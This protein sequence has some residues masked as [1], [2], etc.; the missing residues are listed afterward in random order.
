MASSWVIFKRPVDETE[1]E[2]CSSVDADADSDV[3]EIKDTAETIAAARA[4]AIQ[5]CAT[6]ASQRAEQIPEPPVDPPPP[7]PPS[8]KRRGCPYKHKAG[9][10]YH[11]YC[12]H[13]CF[14]GGDDKHTNNCSGAGLPVE[15][16]RPP[17]PPPSCRRR[18]CPYEHKAGPRHHGYCCHGCRR[19]G[20]DEHTNNCSGAG[21]PVK[22]PPWRALGA[23]P[24]PKRQRT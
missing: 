4:R 23:A 13:G 22:L 3:V 5:R 7:P 21:L 20:D 18:G 11:G 24:K 16:D 12:C 1:A 8:C 15:V 17:A 2:T 6:I 9:P 10:R 19:G 14:R